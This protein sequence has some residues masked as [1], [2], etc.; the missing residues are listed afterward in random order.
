MNEIVHFAKITTGA[1]NVK[2]TLT[3]NQ[4]RSSYENYAYNA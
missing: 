2:G 1:I 3:F 4:E